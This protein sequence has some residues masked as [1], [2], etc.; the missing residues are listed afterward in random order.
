MKPQQ[1]LVFAAMLVICVGCDHA[2]KRIAESALDGPSVSLAGDALRF[3]LVYNP[4]AFLGFG[5][6]LPGGVRGFL[7]QLLVP[8]ALA[9]V[10]IAAL[11]SGVASHWSLVGLGMM[12]GG[13]LGNWLDRLMNGGLVTDFVSL[14][15]GPLRTGVFNLAD[16]YIM[17]GVA[18]ALLGT[19]ES[20]GST[21]PPP[22]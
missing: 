9:G 22:G 1:I 2:A 13:G 7:L 10:C 5:S 4:G 21:E 3:E 15:V 18:L 12:V 14:G 8:V 6:E 20:S 19:R 17:A 11:R 16:V